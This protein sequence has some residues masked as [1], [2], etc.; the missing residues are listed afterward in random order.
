M[1]CGYTPPQI[2]QAYG[3]DRV[4]ET[5]SGVRIAITDLYYSPTLID[6]ANRFSRHYGLPLLSSANFQQIIPSNVNHVP[7]GDP[8]HGQSWW[9]EQT[10]DLEAA[11][12]MSPDAF[13]VFVAGVCDAV[14]EPEG[15]VA[16]QPLYAV[17]KC[18][19][20]IVQ[21]SHKAAEFVRM[22]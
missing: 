18:C 14:D 21:G 6:D 15:G 19:K 13:I 9:G 8:C 7:Q 2:Q 3:A 11:H 4:S 16:L 10:L 22:S 17:N 1:L 5:G 12:A 20:G